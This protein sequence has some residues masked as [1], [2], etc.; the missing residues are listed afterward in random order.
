[1]ETKYFA[2]EEAKSLQDYERQSI[3]EL[4]KEFRKNA[5]EALLTSAKNIVLSHE[6]VDWLFNVPD[7]DSGELWEHFVGDDLII[8]YG[9]H[10][11]DFIRQNL[12]EQTML[13]FAEELK[14]DN[15]DSN[16]AWRA[17]QRMLLEGI[18]A[19]VKSV[20]AS[21]DLI[22]QDLQKLDALKAQLDQ[23]R[24]MIERRLPDELFQQELKAAIL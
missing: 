19:D 24:D 1:M 14:T 18:Y 21:Q 7:V 23:L 2:L 17:F 22:N 16:R 6:L 11:R 10:F 13:W 12:I 15:R 20:Q 8:P 4:F 5:K 3:R 9:S